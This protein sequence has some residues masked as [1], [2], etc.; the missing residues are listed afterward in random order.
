MQ[1]AGV[2]A[3]LEVSAITALDK[4]DKV[5]SDGVRAELL[6]RGVSDAAISR[7]L[8]LVENGATLE[9]VQKFLADH[10]AGLEALR[11]IEE[12]L[13][14]SERT[15]AAGLVHFDLSLA[16]GLGYYTGTIVELASEALKGSLGGGGRY[17]G[18]VGM[19]LGKEVPA[20]G[21][22]LGLERLLLVMEERGLFPAE[23]GQIDVLIGA[24]PGEDGA[25]LLALAQRLRGLGLSV[26]VG[27]KFDKAAKLRKLATESRARRCLYL[28]QGSWSLLADE[29]GVRGLADDAVPAA[30]GLPPT[31]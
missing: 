17:N 8:V 25:R 31:A 10:A 22:S 20:C 6:E 3:D 24:V 2:P 5:G 26:S 23:L 16:R 29:Q 1:R 14:L 28:E 13:R 21:L 15:A 4:L 30:L 7:L 19:F 11:E 18:L 12:V 9:A 27:G